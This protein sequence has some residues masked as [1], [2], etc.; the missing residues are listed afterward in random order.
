MGVIK[1]LV[2]DVVQQGGQALARRLLP[3][4]LP[5]T[6]MTGGVLQ[7]AAR[8]SAVDTGLLKPLDAFPSVVSQ[9]G[10]NQGLLGTLD[11]PTKIPGQ[12]P[13]PAWPGAREFPAGSRATSFL[14]QP[15][16][17][18][19]TRGGALAPR[20]EA[21]SAPRPAVDF[22]EDLITPSMPTPSAPRV[23]EELGGDLP[24]RQRAGAEALTEYTTSKGAVRQ[25]G[26]KL[27]G[28]PYSGK[29][30]A[31]EGN[32]EAA[33]AA[34]S[35]ELSPSS[36]LREGRPF[37]GEELGRSMFL[38]EGFPDMFTGEYRI[39]PELLRRLP[40]EAVERFVRMGRQQTPEMSPGIRAAFGVD[41]GPAPVDLASDR[42]FELARGL[43]N[44]A[45]GARTLDLSGIDPRVLLAFG[46][47]ASA[48]AL[49][50]DLAMSDR[51]E[52]GSARVGEV[53]T[54]AQAPEAS[55]ADRVLDLAQLILN[56]PAGANIDPRKLFT[57]DNGAPLA[58]VGI[59]QGDVPSSANA[60]TT[61]GGIEKNSAEL[62]A[63]AQANPA[64]A[65]AARMLAPM[66]PEKYS[67]PREYFAAREAYANKPAVRDA[68]AAFAG[69][70]AS[71]PEMATNLQQW[72]QANPALAYELQRR[73]LAN[74]AANQQ[75]AESVTTSAIDTPLGS[76]NQANAVGNAQAVGAAAVAPT[77]GN[78]DM[79]AATSIQ[80][81]PHLQL[82]QRLINQARQ[83][84]GLF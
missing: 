13:K 11:V 76:D 38:D 41:A 61:S 55:G 62:A 72:A 58:P 23:A 31:T 8:Q 82:T 12:A 45:A 39:D 59:P 1:D 28:Q 65:A 35:P 22:T 32:I 29:P 3:Q 75:S 42:A 52:G 50:L 49:G 19:R 51:G 69:S 14:P 2:W 83:R 27:G 43:R 44:S 30:Y 24:L 16:Q 9:R 79:A 81:K 66:S 20:M 21:P 17:G 54:T 67:S 25:P 71:S 15:Y 40:P 47:G 57:E 6:E 84:A 68:L 4:I 77:Q 60:M 48:A 36:F 33:R 7:K 56:S 73:A 80:Q 74:P 70:T 10:M 63:L 64:A 37:A 78:F 53:P 46:G 18:P 34:A 5:L 26:T